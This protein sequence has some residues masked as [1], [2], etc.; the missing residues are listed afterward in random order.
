MEIEKKKLNN[1]IEKMIEIVSDDR[2][3]IITTSECVEK[4]IGILEK[5][6]HSVKCEPMTYKEINELKNNISQLNKTQQIEVF[7]IISSTGKYSENSNGVF[8]NLS[9]LSDE[10]LWKL[11]KL[12]NYSLKNNKNF[13]EEQKERIIFEQEQLQYDTTEENIVIKSNNE[14][15]IESDLSHENILNTS[16][17]DVESQIL[18][19]EFNIYNELVLSQNKPKYSG[20][21]ARILKKCKDMSKA[22]SETNINH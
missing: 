2:D 9:N 1:L 19:E 18:Q 10:I 22:E 8:V 17:T 20:I 11:D 14:F 5:K 7:K 6:I 21:E 3:L 12:V 4:I 13:D 16:L 15:N